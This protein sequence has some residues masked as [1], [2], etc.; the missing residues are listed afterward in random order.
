MASLQKITIIRYID[1]NGNRVAKGTPG[2]RKMKEESAKY[3]ACWREGGK[4][5]RVPLA[6]DKAVSQVMLADLLK[7]RERGESGLADPRKEHLDA[8]LADHVADYLAALT[9]SEAHYK[10]VARV[11]RLFIRDGKCARLRDVS[12]DR[13]SA[14]LG[15]IMATASRNR[16]RRLILTMLNWCESVGR[17][18]RNPLTRYNVKATK[19]TSKRLRRALAVEEVQTLLLAVRDYPLKSASVNTGGRN[20]KKNPTARPAKL[21]PAYV[22]RLERRGRE[23]WLLYR[24]AVL[25]G[26][27]R[28]ELSRMRVQHLEL[29]RQPF[30]R[31]NLPGNLTKSGKAARILL[32]PSL[33]ADLR[34]WIADTGKRPGDKLLYVPLVC[35]M[36]KLHKAHLAAA[37]I[38]YQVDGKFADFHSL[39]M[40][41]NVLLRKAGIPAK[42]R[43]LFMRHGTLALTTETYDDADTAEMATVVSALASMN[44]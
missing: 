43:Q 39:R 21:S 32:V 36:V 40:V 5:V 4:H 1:R 22:A 20:A 14:Y 6:T 25:T 10:E 18:E 42:E 24:L 38:A 12:P 41:P 17:I 29:D 13:V 19:K 8:P 35:N 28:G 30:A 31:L 27:R 9:A 26:L 34:Q 37:G 33:A 3:Y 23:R 15:G 2:A 16:H 7:S 44:L 11:L